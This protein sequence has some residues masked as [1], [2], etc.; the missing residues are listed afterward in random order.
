MAY[1]VNIKTFERIEKRQQ[2]G[3]F[4][5]AY[6]PAIRATV[7]EAPRISRPSTIVAPTLGR[8]VHVLSTAELGF[9][10]LALMH[11]KLVDLHEQKVIPRWPASHPTCGL[12]GVIAADLPNFRGSIQVADSLGY[13]DVL[14]YVY[15]RDEDGR[16]I[17]IVYPY[18]GDL[19]LF[20]NDADGVYCVNWSVKNQTGDHFKPGPEVP[21]PYSDTELRKARARHEIEVGT[22]ADAGIRTVPAAADE[23]D[24]NLVANLAR[25]YPFVIGE[26]EL[27]A[28][29]IS[30]LKNCFAQVFEVGEP[31]DGTITRLV[32]RGICTVWEA[33]CVLCKMIYREEIEVDMFSPIIFDRPLRW[34]SHSPFERY[35]RWFSR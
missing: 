8:E 31:P 23:L 24:K 15:D 32:G 34:R 12:P 7:A 26:A 5:S 3:R 19:L 14:P 18:L 20:L 4:G 13:R 2:P 27:P 9:A 29:V 1:R 17:P 6:E 35:A 30:Y 11:P 10:L 33:Q 21:K 22:Y 16:R 28:S 25:I